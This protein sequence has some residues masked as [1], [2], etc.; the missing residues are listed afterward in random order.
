MHFLFLIGVIFFHIIFCDSSEP[1]VKATIPEKVRVKEQFIQDYF[2]RS[3]RPGLKQLGLKQRAKEFLR[4]EMIKD[5]RSSVSFNLL[6][7]TPP[8]KEKENFL[9]DRR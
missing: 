8:K 4:A 2:N 1:T 3:E 6:I 7:A 5:Q 9:H